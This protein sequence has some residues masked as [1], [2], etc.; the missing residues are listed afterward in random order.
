M[1]RHNVRT[2][3]V[4]ATQ[5]E[6]IDAFKAELK[7]CH[8]RTSRSYWVDG[9]KFIARKTNLHGVNLTVTKAEPLDKSA[10]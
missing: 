3:R 5:E 7:D 6:A 10:E 4:F 2:K 8:H 1:D 9:T